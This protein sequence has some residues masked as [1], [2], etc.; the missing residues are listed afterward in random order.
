MANPT[1]R[2]VSVSG[3]SGQQLELFESI[4][5]RGVQLFDQ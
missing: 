2:V 1:G 5:D 4:F 3:P